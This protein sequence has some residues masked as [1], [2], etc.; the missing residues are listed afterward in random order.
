MDVTAKIVKKMQPVTGEGKNGKWVKQEIIVET[1]EQYPRKICI[2]F[3]GDKCNELNNF[4]LGDVVKIFINIESREFNERWYTDVRAWKLEAVSKSN[5]NE[6]T[7][8]VNYGNDNNN[9]ENSQS[10]IN[11]SGNDSTGNY[12]DLPF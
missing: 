6:Q 4:A 12:N 10:F 11:T 5:T 7:S 2:S 9:D 1:I 3:W 8:S